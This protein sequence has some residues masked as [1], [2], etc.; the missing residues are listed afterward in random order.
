MRTASK[1]VSLSD[2]AKRVRQLATAIALTCACAVS[3]GEPNSKA[4]LLHAWSMLLPTSGSVHV[5]ILEPA[6]GQRYLAGYDFR[7]GAFYKAFSSH[8]G[9]QDP[10]GSGFDGR[11][12]AG[13]VKLR[14]INAS[15]VVDT[16]LDQFIPFVAALDFLA[17]PNLI[18]DVAR[19][20]DGFMLTSVSPHGLRR[21]SSPPGGRD[22]TP[23]KVLYHYDNRGCLREIENYCGSGT[24][25]RWEYNDE[26]LAAH[27]LA[28]DVSLGTRR[29]ID[30][31]FD[32]AGQ[33][34]DFTAQAVERLAVASALIEVSQPLWFG[35]RVES[36]GTPSG[37]RQRS[38]L[39][40]VATTPEEADKLASS[41]ESSVNN[42]KSHW[43]WVGLG[44]ALIV[45]GLWLKRRFG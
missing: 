2:S 44:A 35:K 33:P 6:T 3:N 15:P 31:R 23:Q 13:Q 8:V 10:S 1:P 28:S 4:E 43:L 18:Q 42:S 16:T 12:V 22:M 17:N 24:P 5:H 30:F 26:R 45:L 40:G 19:R 34:G 32:A 38:K 20:A 9:G 25:M 14:P 21:D 37:I 11:P 7:S 27:G 39:G 29:V 36:L 41:Q